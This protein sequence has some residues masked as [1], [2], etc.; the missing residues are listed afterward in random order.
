[1]EFKIKLKLDK[2]WSIETAD[3]CRREGDSFFFIRDGATSRAIFASE[4]EGPPIEYVPN[5][6]DAARWDRFVAEG[7][8][9]YRSED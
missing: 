9:L 6:E 5:P 1:M 2:G 3:E 4:L 7:D 8:S